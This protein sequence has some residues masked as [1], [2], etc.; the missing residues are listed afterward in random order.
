MSAPAR[1]RRFADNPFYVLGVSPESP[2][3]QVEREGQKLLGMLE[4][5]LRAAATCDTPVGPRPRSP[6]S[7]RAA[8][9]EVRTPEKR[10]VHELWAALPAKAE[11]EA[12]ADA[13]EPAGDPFRRG[14]ESGPPP[15]QSGWPLAFALFGWR[16]P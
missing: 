11:A 3:P 15:T 8:M 9:A 6:E 16:R 7:V 14:D 12:K 13:G 2:R 1:G 10:L 4:L 5:G